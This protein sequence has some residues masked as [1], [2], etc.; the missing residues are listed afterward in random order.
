[1][2]VTFIGVGE[3]CDANYPNTSLLLD[4]PGGPPFQV[5]LDCGFTTPHQYFKSCSD[6]DALKYLWISHFHGDHF[7]GTPLLLLR[8]GEMGRQA[9]LT[10]VGPAGVEEK[11][12]QALSLAY[13]G[14]LTR[15][16]FPLH[17]STMAPGDEM[18]D[19]GLHWRCALSDHSRPS[20]VVRIDAAGTSLFYS[21]DGRPT[22]QSRDLAGGCRLIVHEA[23][24]VKG[25]TPGHGTV[26]DCIPFAVK[27][28]AE[29]LAL[30]H[31]SRNDRKN[32]RPE[33]MGMISQ[34]EACRV[35]LPEPGDSV[36]I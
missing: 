14:F 25:E 2:K 36:L 27:A 26:A 11:I 4:V 24:R 3:A 1:M 35:F 31:V 22:S 23:F 21:G 5:M 17:Y 28:G 7:F 9:P 34:V 13:S 32:F 30:V 12:E 18:S 16:E 19:G 10:I 20:L 29:M 33:I 6:P 8:L 15:K